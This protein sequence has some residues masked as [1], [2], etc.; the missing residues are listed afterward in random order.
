[1]KRHIFST[2]VYLTAVFAFGGC[3]QMSS[4]EKVQAN[5]ESQKIIFSASPLETKQTPETVRQRKP[6]LPS[7]LE[8]ENPPSSSKTPLGKFDFKNFTYPLLRGW[9]DQDSEEAELIDGKRAINKEK[10]GLELVRTQ[11]GD[12]TGDGAENALVILRIDTGGSSAPH[13]VYI[14][15]WKDDKP[16]LLWHFRTGDR[17]NGGL[18]KVWA[19]NGELWLELW[20]KDRYLLGQIETMKVEGDDANLCCPNFYTRSHY[21]WNGKNFTLRGERQTFDV[22]NPNAQTPKPQ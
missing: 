17:A 1:M 16:E 14:F 6:R 15:D 18:K 5:A 2:V 9:Q 13:L 8:D 22:Q 20:S 4:G 21:A 11:F 10:I 19:E 7:L 12:F 3:R